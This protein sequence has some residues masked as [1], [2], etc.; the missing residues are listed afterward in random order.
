[1]EPAAAPD[2]IKVAFI[3]SCA[4]SGSTWLNLVLGSNSWAASLGEFRQPFDRPGFLICN[5]CHADG[6]DECDVLHGLEAVPRGECFHF[7]ASRMQKPVL[8]DASK[9][10]TWVGGFVDRADLDVRLI[11]LVRH[12]CG[13]VESYGRRNPGLTE[14]EALAEWRQRNTDVTGFLERSGRPSIT[15]CYDD[16]AD[17]PARHF[18][19]LCDFLGHPWEPASLRFWEI[20]HHGPGGGGASSLFLRGRSRISYKTADDDFYRDMKERPLAADRRWKTK[21]SAEVRAMLTGDPYAQEMARRL[22]KT[23]WEV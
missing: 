10:I 11:R 20:A 5:L 1:M 9:W 14:R 4:R 6:K 16:L 8:I 13:F 7:A 23:H 21:L 2:K 15:V 18:P 3:L 19:P 12:P 22:G 17:E